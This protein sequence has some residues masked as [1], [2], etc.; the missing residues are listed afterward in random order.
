M[1]L[2][3]FRAVEP[4]QLMN[5]GEIQETFSTIALEEIRFFLNT[6]WLE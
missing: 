5:M 4:A 3:Y 1:N 6:I 2:I